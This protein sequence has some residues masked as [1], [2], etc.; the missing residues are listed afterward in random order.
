M[1][2]LITGKKVYFSYFKDA[3]FEFIAERQWEDGF[4]RGISYDTYH[5]SQPGDWADLQGDKNDDSRFSFAVIEKELNNF[6]GWVSLSG[7]QL[8][9]RGAMASIAIVGKE[10]RGKGYGS[11][12]LNTL[13]KFS[14]CELGLN[15][16]RLGV[17]S[18]NQGAINMYEKAGFVREG[19]DRHG[20]FEDGQFIDEYYYGI[21]ASEWLALQK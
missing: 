11:D 17:H 13:L 8:K 20:H 14:F 4:L 16:V 7:V 9:S 15:K 12:A 3:Y 6:V 1:E 10:N 2:N 19:V 5:P 21:L 18:S